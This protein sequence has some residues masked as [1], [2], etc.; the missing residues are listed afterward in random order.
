MY[1]TTQ[2]GSLGWIDCLYTSPHWASCLGFACSMIEKKL[3]LTYSPKWCFFMVVY[4]G[5]IRKNKITNKNTS[6][7]FQF[8]RVFPHPVESSWTNRWPFNKS[9]LCFQLNLFRKGVFFTPLAHPTL[10]LCF[11]LPVF[12]ASRFLVSTHPRYRTHTRPG[13]AIPLV[14]Q[15]WKKSLKLALVEVWGGVQTWDIQNPR[16]H[17]WWSMFGT[18]KS[19]AKRR[20]ERGFKYLLKWCLDAKGN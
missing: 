18:P 19:R 20:C 17:T 6:N 4:Q 11:S 16:K 8:G 10:H 9:K 1:L 14:R 7:K 15:W 2:L 13:K 12:Q 5:K 3:Q